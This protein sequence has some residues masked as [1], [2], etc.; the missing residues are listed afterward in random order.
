MVVLYEFHLMHMC[1]NLIASCLH[2]YYIHVKVIE[3]HNK[4]SALEQIWWHSIP[5]V[6]QVVVDVQCEFSFPTEA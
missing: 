2:V 5:V 6:Q 1:N 4:K 3:H